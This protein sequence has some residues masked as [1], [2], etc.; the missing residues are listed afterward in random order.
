MESWLSGRKRRFAKPLN[1]ETGS[2][3]SNPSLSARFL[4]IIVD[5]HS[6]VAYNE[7]SN[8]QL[9]LEMFITLNAVSTGKPMII[10]TAHLVGVVQDG[11][12][13]WVTSYKGQAAFKVTETI[14]QIE[15]ILMRAELLVI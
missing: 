2:E 9:E 13:V 14:D 15:R 10:N 7:S 3:G 12:E 5:I 11:D 4:K 6:I 1:R 8:E